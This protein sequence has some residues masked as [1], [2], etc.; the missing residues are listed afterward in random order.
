VVAY[1]ELII[2]LNR[3]KKMKDGKLLIRFQMEKYKEMEKL[4]NLIK[5]LNGKY[6]SLPYKLI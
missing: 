3:A 1:W 5:V 6:I 2:I 4:F